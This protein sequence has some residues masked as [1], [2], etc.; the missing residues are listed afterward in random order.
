MRGINTGGEASELAN[1]RRAGARPRSVHFM[2][3]N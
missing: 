2:V 3:I 1:E